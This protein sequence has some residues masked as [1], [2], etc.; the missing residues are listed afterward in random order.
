MYAECRRA[1]TC[2]RCPSDAPM[3]HEMRA[4]NESCVHSHTDSP[5]EAVVTTMTAIVYRSVQRV[6]ALTATAVVCCVHC[7]RRLRASISG[8][9]LR[10]SIVAAKLFEN[11]RMMRT[12]SKPTII[13]HLYK[14]I[15][16]LNVV[17]ATCCQIVASR[18]RMV[19]LTQWQDRQHPGRVR[20][21]D[22]PLCLTNCS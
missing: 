14:V 4:D 13:A 21:S 1:C 19:S 5:P 7:A 12:F 2:A 17:C 16:P 22:A 20:A 10:Y 18:V 8:T 9:A 6:S 3:L 15:S 11:A